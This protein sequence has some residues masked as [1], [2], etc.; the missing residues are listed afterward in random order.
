M[1]STLERL[2]QWTSESLEPVLLGLS[3]G[4]DDTLALL[5]ELGYDLQT[6]PA[7]V[8]ALA[9]PAGRI[10]DA[11]DELLTAAIELAEAE[12]DDDDAL[13][14]LSAAGTALTIAIVELIIKLDEMPPGPS[15]PT[16]MVPEELARRLLDWLIVRQLDFRGRKVSSIMRAAGVIDA[17]LVDPVPAGGAQVP[18]V[19][20]RPERSIK[21]LTNPG[22]LA[23]DVYHWGEAA[24][25]VQQVFAR[26]AEVAL[27]FNREFQLTGM[28]T[29][30]ATLIDTDPDEAGQVLHVPVLTDPIRLDAVLLGIPGVVTSTQTRL[31][32]IGLTIELAAAAA[33]TFE[34]N[35]RTSLILEGA[36]SLA[37]GLV[38]IK[39]PTENV[40]LKFDISGATVAAEASAKLTLVRAPA[41]G[42]DRV[43]L[44]NVA[45]TVI[46]DADEARI[47]LGASISN[48][49]PDVLTEIL[50]KEGLLSVGTGSADGF[51]AKMLPEGG[52]QLPVDLHL[53]WSKSGG[54][55]F[56]GG[57]GLKI[58][59]TKHREIGPLKI[60][61]IEVSVTLGTTGLKTT[62]ALDL[63]LKIG[64]LS[65]TVAEMGARADIAFTAGNL[66]PAD[67][68]L[69]FKPPSG[70]G[71]SIKSGPVTGGGF[72]F[73]DPDN[74]QYAGILQLSIQT[75]NITVIGLLTTKLPDPSGAPGATKKGFSLL[76]IVAVEFPPIQLGYGFALIGDR[77]AARAC[78]GRC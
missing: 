2:A 10:L 12:E 52:L 45:D 44:L 69:G 55:R 24:F 4:E 21:A 28:N 39:R 15:F 49:G 29:A 70:A 57:T 14:A 56:E 25:D 30:V 66:G 1:N 16:G 50:L 72:V 78:T 18:V 38:L 53:T 71:F 22:G 36:G 7:P 31:P 59:S 35:E 58:R 11:F 23:K 40:E 47:A 64:P 3:A 32:G 43:T 8:M 46:L 75:I 48:A 61:M 34:L 74:E 51:L 27:A 68:T 62:G 33:T 54:L 13:S 76:L 41:P 60:E 5:R 65:A 9:Q 77:R 20:L 17:E 19:R 73:F 42:E 67:L 26:I 6:A 37:G 63:G